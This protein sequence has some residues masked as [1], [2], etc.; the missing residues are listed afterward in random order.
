MSQRNSSSAS[1]QTDSALP[2]ISAARTTPH[3]VNMARNWA[4]VRLHVAFSRADHLAQHFRT[5]HKIASGRIPDDFGANFAHHDPAED[6]WHPQSRPRFPCRIPGCTKTGD[7][8]Y[9]RQIGLDEHIGWTHYPLQNDMPIQQE[10]DPTSACTNNGFQQNVHLQTAQMF[11][12]DAQQNYISQPDLI[13]NFLAGGPFLEDGM[14]VENI[15]F[16]P[17]DES[18]IDPAMDSSLGLDSWREGYTQQRYMAN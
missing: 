12:Q 2:V 10:L 4:I 13:E 7:L 3:F 14:F 8:A 18:D 5:F 6:S 16:P 1:S 15:G 11:G 17:H 9:L